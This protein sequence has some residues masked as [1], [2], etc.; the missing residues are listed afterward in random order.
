MQKITILALHLDFGG[1][2]K[3]ISLLCK[4]FEKDFDI[5]IIST[6]KFRETPAFNF[7]NNIKI[8]Y[9]ITDNLENVS[10]KKLLKNKKFIKI[11]KE[12]L[13]RSKIKRLAKTSNIKVIQSLASD[14]VITTRT[15]HNS[16]VN[17][18][19]KNSNIIKIATEHNY[20]N[21]DK[22][23]IKKLIKSVT[24][25]DYV[26]HCTQ[27]LYD[28]YKD[29]IKNAKNILIPN[30][31]YIESNNISSLN[32]KNIL[33]VG[34]ISPEK[35]FFDL[36]DVMEILNSLDK[37]IHLTICGDGYQ[38]ND[39]K[40]YIESKKLD[41]N[42]IVTG[43][44][45]GKDLENKYLNASIFVMTSITE[46]FGLVLLEAM[47]YGLPCI[48][49]SSASGARYLLKDNTGILIDNRNKDKMAKTIIDLLNDKN[50]LLYYQN[51]SLSRVKE[52][53]L[54]HIYK[55]WKDLIFDK[56]N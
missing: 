37:D 41:K 8:K 55:K 2:E 46:A 22:K 31:V 25:F 11:L 10:I 52:F 12:I 48:S 34:R 24:N 16:L 47:H 20:H 30:P 51:K 1:I 54:E 38:I 3:Y 5:E 26:V 7:D 9:L 29:K 14:Y 15:F 40:S 18:Y 35:G 21:N 50:S 33:A 27:E 42:I 32:N 36:V 23:Y 6:Y 39:L 19:L 56:V 44:L 45:S 17:K 49:F 28:F 43:F 4:M 53:D 13:R